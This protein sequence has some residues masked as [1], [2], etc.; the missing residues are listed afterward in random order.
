MTRL[1]SEREMQAGDDSVYALGAGCCGHHSTD[2]TEAIVKEPL[3]PAAVTIIAIMSVAGP[4]W[5]AD[6]SARGQTDVGTQSLPLPPKIFA[7]TKRRAVLGPAPSSLKARDS[8]ILEFL[9]WKEQWSAAS[10]RA[11]ERSR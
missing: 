10:H 3:G 8:H 2:E 1:V 5:A 9:S 4:A 7:L 11:A 6:W